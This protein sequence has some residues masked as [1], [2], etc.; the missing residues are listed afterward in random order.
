LRN[1]KSPLG[2]NVE[3]GKAHR[4]FDLCWH[5][6][7]WD[8]DCRHRR[9]RVGISDVFARRWHGANRDRGIKPCQRNPQR[10]ER[11]AP[12]EA[13]PRG[14]TVTT[15][16]HKICS[17][18][19]VTVGFCVALAGCSGAHDMPVEPT[20]APSIPKAIP[21]IK[22]AAGQY[23]LAGQLQI[24]GPIEAPAA[25]LTPWVICLKSGSEPRFTVALFYKGDTFVSS[26]VATLGDRCD[27]Q[28]YQPLP[29]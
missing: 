1:E 19:L 7:L 24:A 3:H 25:S 26:R 20:P 16:H 9:T 14:C 22:I 11:L 29:P 18:R 12:R 5:D 15:S 2:L 8:L 17:P 21:V 10:P 4:I 27:S 13:C 6:R 28:A 23:H